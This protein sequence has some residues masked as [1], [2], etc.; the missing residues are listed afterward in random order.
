MI[1]HGGSEATARLHVDETPLDL[2]S[3]EVL[4]ESAL[5]GISPGTELRMLQN[6]LPDYVPGY[7][8]AGRVLSS[9][10][11]DWPEGT[12]VVCAGGR[13]PPGLTRWYG[14]H[15]SLHAVKAD[16]VFRVP[17]GLKPQE[18]VHNKLAAIAHRGLKAGNAQAGE[19]VLVIGLGMIGAL[20]ARLWL[21]AGTDVMAVDRVAART[22]SAA[23][24]GCRVASSLDDVDGLFDVVVDCTGSPAVMAAA[25]QKV[26]QDPWSEGDQP[27][28][29]YILQGSYT[30]PV[31]FDYQTAFERQIS[32][33]LPRDSTRSDALATL[34]LVAEGRLRIDDLLTWIADP[35]DAASVYRD[36]TDP[37]QAASWCGV[38][39]DWR[40]NS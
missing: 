38:A 10:N 36:L 35:A 25:M 1:V 19:K 13:T 31:T 33:V 26:R 15:Q 37:T 39:F 11:R 8:V 3:G 14:G 12:E 2:E 24:A 28:P 16:D 23:R 34:T 29:R 18:V 22:E 27:G 21:G 30:G 6:G 40:L 5:T 9:G 7:C 20:A 4:V 17:D 32:M